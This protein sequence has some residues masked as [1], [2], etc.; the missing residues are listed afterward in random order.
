VIDNHQAVDTFKMEHQRP[1]PSP[2]L[3]ELGPNDDVASE[4]DL[5]SHADVVIVGAGMTGCSLAYHLCTTSSINNGT[6]DSVLGGGGV[7]IHSVVCIDG[8]CI[9]GGASGRNGG[10]MW[11]CIDEG[12]QMRTAAK[13]K[14]FV[15]EH[16]IDAHMIEGAG[17]S[18]VYVDDAD[19]AE[20]DLLDSRVKKI[21]PVACMAAPGVF[22]CGYFDSSV[23]SF[24]P[25]KVVRGLANAALSTKGST[26]SVK[27]VLGC[28][29]RSIQVGDDDGS[30]GQNPA[31]GGDSEG[32]G[33]SRTGSDRGDHRVASARQWQ[34]SVATS[35]GIIKCNRVIVAANGWL[36][37][38]VPEL[39]PYIRACTNTVL[40][41]SNPIPTELLWRVKQTTAGYGGVEGPRITSLVCGDGANEVY[42]AVREDGR[43]VLGGMRGGDITNT[44]ST[45]C[46]SE[47]EAE[48]LGAGDDDTGAGNPEIAEALQQWFSRAFPELGAQ[49][50]FKHSW[51]GVLGFPCDDNPITGHLQGALYKG[52]V[53]VC[54]G[55]GGEGMSRC[56]GLAQSLVQDIYGVTVEESETAKA[57]D[58]NR[59]K[60]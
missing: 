18:L 44:V 25:A 49:L 23:T 19:I 20:D 51:L 7:G 45:T 11:P 56:F 59:F 17:V 47:S 27:F 16:N 58:V 2:W 35:K 13:M 52:K 57:W 1:G 39:K 3:E 9:S 41:S 14:A 42:L 50:E 22:K 12:F 21:D 26:T 54:G 37:K 6:V 4:I 55:F 10:I 53:S 28:Y 60:F 24:W 46:G 8:R 15:V 36:P 5:P 33:N 38:V 30:N 40:I 43:V 48:I 32:M 29:A 34:V 31:A